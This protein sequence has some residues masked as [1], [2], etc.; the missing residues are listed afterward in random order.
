MEET[1]FL[2]RKIIDLDRERIHTRPPGQKGFLG[3]KGEANPA[4]VLRDENVLDIRQRHAKGTS[5]RKLAKGYGIAYSHAHAIV[6]R[7]I[8]AHI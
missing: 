2:P 7:S 4:S 6:T 8:W 1:H 5:I 3:L